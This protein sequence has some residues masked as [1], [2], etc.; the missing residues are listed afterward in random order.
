MRILFLASREIN[1][2]RLDVLLRAFKRFGQVETVCYSERASVLRRSIQVSLKAIPHLIRRNHFDLV[3]VGFY[4]HLIMF[5]VKLFANKPILFDAFISTYDTLCFDRGQ[6]SPTSIPGKMTYRLD[7]WSC[8][9]ADKILIDTD[10]HLD[11]FQKTFHLPANRLSSLPVGC[12]EDLFYP[13]TGLEPKNKFT[14]LYY[15]SYMPLHGVE[16]VLE[17][18]NLLRDQ[19]IEFKLIGTGIQFPSIQQK[20][21]DHHLNNVEFVPYMP[22]KQLPQEIASAQICLGGHFG[23]TEK[24]GRVIPGKIYQIL[25]MSKPLIA[26]NSP[27]NR[28]LLTSLENAW[29]VPQGNAQELAKAIEELYK[30]QDFRQWLGNQ[31]RLLYEKNCS[32][33]YITKRLFDLTELLIHS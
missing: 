13:L 6:F 2:P 10:Q 29:L 31:G 11:Y 33:T 30:N 14:V 8:F 18:A 16:F 17:A 27:A 25:A 19:P 20:A 1:Y 15:C 12:N 7:R 26:S 24:A 3:F 22:L 9:L 32:E 21:H 28:E 5:P 23:L 4:G